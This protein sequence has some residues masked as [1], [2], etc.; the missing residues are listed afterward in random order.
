MS[1]ITT[2]NYTNPTNEKIEKYTY[3]QDGT[4]VK[5]GDIVW[6][7]I[8]QFYGSDGYRLQPHIITNIDQ[9]RIQT[10]YSSCGS[11]VWRKINRFYST[12]IIAQIENPKHT[13]RL[14][15]ILFRDFIQSEKDILTKDFGVR[16]TEA[17][18]EDW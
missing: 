7:W 9:A 5:I 15:S 13:K 6:I 16:F 1:V 10:K 12:A 8:Q 18:V 14:K 17:L 11:R 2:D 3:L 4:L